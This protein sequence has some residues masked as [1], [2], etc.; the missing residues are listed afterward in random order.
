MAERDFFRG[1]VREG[2]HCLATVL[3]KTTGFWSSKGAQKEVLL[4]IF[5]SI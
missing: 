4:T 2:S 5:Q 1:K 3:A